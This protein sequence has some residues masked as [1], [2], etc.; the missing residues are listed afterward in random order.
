MPP[1]FTTARAVINFPT[2][3]PAGDAVAKRRRRKLMTASKI[4]GR[5]NPIN[6][7]EIRQRLAERD[8]RAA[9]DNRTPAEIWL[10][11]PPRAQSALA[12]KSE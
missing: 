9:S 12:Q 3:D 11:D 2:I 6:P 4:I 10:G 7:D 1:N 8:A 5:V